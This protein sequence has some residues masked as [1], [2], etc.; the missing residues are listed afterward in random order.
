MV[1]T[2]EDVERIHEIANE[3]KEL[4]L[5]QKTIDSIHRWANE[6]KKRLRNEARYGL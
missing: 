2:A 1:K 6:E 5:P 4:G 3:L